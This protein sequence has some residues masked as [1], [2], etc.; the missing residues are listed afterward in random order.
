MKE[1]TIKLLCLFCLLLLPV[2]TLAGEVKLSVAASLKDV[3]NELADGFAKKHP[4]VRFQKNYGASGALAKQIES[5]A[6]SDMY[7]SANLEWMSY[8]KNRKLV[9]AASI[10]TFTYNTLVFIGSSGKK[11]S[12]MN[13]LFKLHNIAIGSPKSVPAGAYAM[14][15][16]KRAGKDKEWENKLVMARDAR[17]CLTYAERGEV[18]GAFVYLTDALQ[19]KKATVLFTVPQGL[20]P[21][22]IYPMAL[23]VTGAKNSDAASFYRFLQ[24][25]EAKVVLRRYGFVK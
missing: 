3:V 18:D 22:V 23:T 17:D 15:A 2:R 24:S 12:G 6:P 7:I 1:P 5:G 14:E 9:D 19:A 8:L 16:I 11:V 25:A 4:D 20:Y 21:P 10:G 13:D